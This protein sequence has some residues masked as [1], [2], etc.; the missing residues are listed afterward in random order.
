MKKMKKK[1]SNR[2]FLSH[3]AGLPETELFLWT[4]LGPWMIGSSCPPVRPCLSEAHT[5][6]AW[7]TEIT[8]STPFKLNFWSP[9]QH[10][11]NLIPSCFLF[12][13]IKVASG[14]EGHYDTS[15]KELISVHSGMNYFSQKLS[16]S[17]LDC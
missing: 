16:I 3:P 12:F 2:T 13:F 8:P 4:A 1:V 14:G 17:R 6:G 7:K 10:D 5:G 11:K 9:F 15:Q